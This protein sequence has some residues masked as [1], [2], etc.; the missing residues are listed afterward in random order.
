MKNIFI[1]L[2]AVTAGLALAEEKQKIGWHKEGAASFSLTQTRMDNYAQ[3]GEDT[4]SWQTNIAFQFNNNHEHW[5]W[6]N[7]GRLRYGRNQ[8]GDERSKKSIDEI[9]L[10]TVYTQMVNEYVNPYFSATGETQLTAGYTYLADSR[11][12]I[13]NF[14]DPAFFREAIGINYTR[15]EIMKA[16]LGFSAKQTI[17]SN[18]PKPFADD[19]ETEKI[20]KIRA[21]YGIESVI[22]VNYKI[23]K[24]SM[25]VSKM[26]IFSNMQ[27]F[28]QIDVKWDTDLT[29]KLTQFISFNFNFLLLYDKTIS[30]KRQIKQVM[31]IG[32]SYSFF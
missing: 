30:P 14:M 16:R 25:I 27:S 18:F 20:E 6:S 5:K 15:S 31:G 4:F 29:A 3:G 2:F 8:M 24:A 10:E 23:S 7:S 13:S 11:G 32:I 26:E 19:P 17:T 28:D 9:K 21:E 1:I 22:D 12:K